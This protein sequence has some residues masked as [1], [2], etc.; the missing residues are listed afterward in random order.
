MFSPESPEKIGLWILIPLIA[1]G[2]WMVYM[3][4]LMHIRERRRLKKADKD[5]DNR[6]GEAFQEK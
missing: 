3:C 2:L 4:I 5:Y 1:L 6:M